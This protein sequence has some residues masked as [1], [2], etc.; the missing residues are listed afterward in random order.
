MKYALLLF[1]EESDTPPSPE[2]MA[3][4]D[5]FG[6]EAAK[7]DPDLSG[8]ALRPSATA[9]VVSVRNGETVTTDGPFIDT[10]E[11]LGGFY[12]VDC[13]DLDVAIELATK[14]PWAPTGHI[15]VRPVMEM[16]G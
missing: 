10:K 15:E 3:E 5:G 12:I 14:I 7:V 6:Q 13:P 2:A 4:W 11:Q 9:T 1:N 16:E 8:R